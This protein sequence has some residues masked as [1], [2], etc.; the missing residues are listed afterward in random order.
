MLVQALLS[1]ASGVNIEQVVCRLREP[2]DADCLERAWSQ[3]VQ[4]HAVLRTRFRWVDVVD[5]VQ[6]VLQEVRLEVARHDWEGS[7]SSGHERRLQLYLEEDRAPGFDLSHAPAMR[8][9]LFRLS[10]DEHVLVWSFHH[11]LLGGGSIAAV[12]REVF[13]LYDAVQDGT[14]VELPSRRPFRDHIAWLLG[15]DPAAEEAYWTAYLRGIDAPVPLLGSRSSPRDPEAEPAF[16]EREIRLSPAA[17]TA[18]REF[19][20]ERGVNLNTL[21]QGVWALLLGRYT[22]RDEVVFGLVRGGRGT[23]VEGVEGMLGLLVN[24]VPARVPLPAE[25]CVCDWLKQIAA[26]NTILRTYEHVALQD[27]TRWSGLPKGVPLFNTI[28]SY[29]TEFLRQAFRD[30]GGRWSRR[31][32]RIVQHAGYPLSVTVSAVAPLQVRLGYDA[33]LW[34]AEAVDRMLGHLE[35]L[36]EQ[37]ASDA[38]IRLSELKLLRDTERQQ[39]LDAWNAT[40]AAYPRDACVHEIFEAQVERT[41]E[42]VAVAFEGEEVTYAELN[43]RAN[44]LAHH[45]RDMGVEPGKRIGIL[46]PRSI[47]LVVAELAIL[48][49]GAAY[50]PL[51]A[52]HPVGRTAFMMVDSGSGIVLSRVSGAFP[53]LPGVERIDVDAV[54]GGHE[55]NMPAGIGGEAVAYVMYTSGSTGTPKG[56]LVPHR[57]ITQLVLSN[58]C[59]DLGAA[60]RVALASNPAFDAATMEVWG[61]LLN[62]GR[63]VV[64]RQEVLLDPAA[65]G[66]LLADEGVTTLLTIPVLLKQYAEV[67]P[68]VLAGLR[69]MTTGG[70]RADPASCGRVLREGG[71]VRVYNCYGPTETTTF[72]IAHPV[73]SVGDGEQSV[74]IGRPKTNARVYVL[75]GAGEPVPVGVAG[76]LY[77]GG[78]GLAH[79]YQN[80]AELTAERF[81]PDPFSGEAGGRLYR[82]GDL[83]RWLREGEIE[84]LGRVDA[85]LKVRGYR[86]EPGEVEVVLRRHESVRDCAVIAREDVAGERQLVGYVV[87]EVEEEAL[88]THLRRSL[89][90]YMVPAAFVAME[91]LPV[92]PNG[93]ATPVRVPARKA[94]LARGL[95]AFS[96]GS[97][98]STKTSPGG[99]NPA[100]ARL[101][102][103][104]RWCAAISCNSYPAPGSTQ[105]P[106]RKGCAYRVSRC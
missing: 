56:V 15:R 3:V 24:T 64:V 73:E 63:I 92:T 43:A 105:P 7:A 76:E 49:S 104:L 4:R 23:G 36:L 25:A 32:I 39:V 50:V 51:D 22:E 71:R 2:V 100:G 1:P 53:S 60:D 5:P 84:Y 35:G 81:V 106:A 91:A 89:P 31:S 82:T 44:R 46:L 19:K 21:M 11:I 12:L 40:E 59:V 102:Y 33:E 38:S 27:V 34:D 69:Y 47:E 41:P 30:M 94:L 90:E 29:Q 80:R 101:S 70:D 75:D 72:V 20:R 68:G 6:E 17:D 52:A 93:A 9:A 45:L 55:G 77:I 62:G 61:P 85:Q 14:D 58:G 96:S 86:I 87:G 16:G 10:P 48:K 66:T 97:M 95:P 18:L 28:F 42:A 57:S 78:W 37:V 98:Y 54:G 65:F 83:G 103:L 26:T 13:T 67:I 79:G 74:P 8:L 88:R 99:S